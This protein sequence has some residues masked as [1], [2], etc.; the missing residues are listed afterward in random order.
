MDRE[1]SGLAAPR[2]SLPP[3]SPAPRDSIP[4][5]HSVPSVRL[6][7][8]STLRPASPA[9]GPNVPVGRSAPAT[10]S[11]PSSGHSGHS[12]SSIDKIRRHVRTARPLLPG[13]LPPSPLSERQGVP[14]SPAFVTPGSPAISLSG[15][16]P[17]TSGIPSA[18]VSLSGEPSGA[19]APIP[20]SFGA[21]TVNA[22]APKRKRVRL[23]G[24]RN[25]VGAAGVVCRVV[26]VLILHRVAPLQPRLQQLG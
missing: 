2:L 19:T 25:V 10:P 4:R 16:I 13:Q 20:P 11:T 14:A 26:V 17:S 5:Y 24:Y 12:D 21:A 23:R 6:P 7:G 22:Q 3:L 15:S 1:V 18:G 9:C 8:L